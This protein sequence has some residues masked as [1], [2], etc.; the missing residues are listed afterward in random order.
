MAFDTGLIATEN[1]LPCRTLVACLTRFVTQAI[2]GG[3]HSPTQQAGKRPLFLRLGVRSRT[4]PRTSS[5]HQPNAAGCSL[6]LTLHSPKFES[7]VRGGGSVISPMLSGQ[8]C[9]EGVSWSGCIARTH[10][11]W[12]RTCPTG[13][14]FEAGGGGRRLL[15]RFAI[16]SMS[17]S[18]RRVNDELAE[19]P[20]RGMWVRS[21]VPH[22]SPSVWVGRSGP[23]CKPP[24]VGYCGGEKSGTG[25][26]WNGK[27]W[28]NKSIVR[29]V[30]TGLH[31]LIG[32]LWDT[33]QSMVTAAL[34]KDR[35]NVMAR[36]FWFLFAPAPVLVDQT[37]MLPFEI[38][39]HNAQS[40]QAHATTCHCRRSWSVDWYAPITA[41]P[42]NCKGFTCTKLMATQHGLYIKAHA[43]CWS[44]LL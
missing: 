21:V 30:G 2:C 13:T 23:T 5:R 10:F 15:T 38:C 43:K 3:D 41:P 36:T 37:F 29:L 32:I 4:L 12:H 14:G 18:P 39:R 6:C 35:E 31:L 42:I 24:F 20:R 22:C 33:K 34:Q 9:L 40:W 44:M 1:P 11:R 28:H 27:I 17:Q 26:I 25:E 16:W 8:V 19:H 7:Q